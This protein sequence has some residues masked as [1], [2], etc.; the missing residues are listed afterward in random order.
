LQR[1]ERTADVNCRSFKFQRLVASASSRCCTAILSP[2][3]HEVIIGPLKFCDEPAERDPQLSSP[4]MACATD[5]IFPSRHNPL[6]QY[7]FGAEFSFSSLVEQNPF[8]FRVYTP[9]PRSPFYDN[10]EPYFVGQKFNERYAPSPQV[11]VEPRQ[12]IALTSTYQ[13]AAAHM[14]WTTRS[15]SP[16]IST[17]FSFLW[18]IWE[19]HRRYQTNVKHDIEIAVIDAK[20]VAHHAVTALELLRKSKPKE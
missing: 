9:K 6:P 20:A 16:F 12:S 11:L 4:M 14:D 15:S 8:I 10:T 1:R 19:A 17:S 7:G 2:R 13:D 5:K 3:R 18:S